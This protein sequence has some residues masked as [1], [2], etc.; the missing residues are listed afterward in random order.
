MMGKTLGKYK[1][2]E[3][4]GTGGMASI[5]HGRD[6]ALGRDVAIKILHPHLCKSKADRERFEREAKL[7]SK[8]KHPHIIEVYEYSGDGTGP[9]YIVTELS[10]IH[11]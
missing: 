3:E 10:L 7:V 9:A 5:Y 8:L 4:L 2:L 11:I 1:I 6:T